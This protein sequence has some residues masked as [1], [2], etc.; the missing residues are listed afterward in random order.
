MRILDMFRN[1]DS[2]RLI[3]REIC[4]IAEAGVNHEGDLDLAYRLVEEAAEGGAD[5]IKFQAYKAGALASVHSP[6]YWDNTKETTRSQYELFQK[7][8]GFGP[9][10]YEKIKLR[11]DSNKIDFLCTAFDIESIEFINDLVDVHK[12]A[13]A[14]IT[15]QP[16]IEY[17]SACGKPVL[18]S[19]GAATLMEIQIALG[20]LGYF[21][22]LLHCVLNYPTPDKNAN[23][24]R[25]QSLHREFPL[26]P[27]GY[28]DHTVP[29]GMMN[30]L[31]AVLLGAVIIEKH[32]TFDKTLPGNDHYHSM[33][34]TDLVAFREK[35]GMMC[36][37][38][39]T[40]E[41]DPGE[42]EALAR[43][44]ARRSLVTTKTL[45]MGHIIIGSDLTWKRPA[46]G[47]M[48]YHLS[49]AIGRK[50]T[51]EL[52]EDTIVKRDDLNGH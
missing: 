24:G 44:H 8:D 16:L 50:T 30:I 38:L 25:I 37:T 21:P 3:S 20:W 43:S 51:I 17:I 33:D 41:I 22:A 34:K 35:W 7:Y 40:G 5:A 11:C 29:D 26:C 10:D 48:P 19:T 4:V 14:D 36:D 46:H 12:I 1:Y 42:N 27:I 15:C 13:S 52:D 9:S 23:L 39:G 47:L 49:W 45:P 18:M 32:F 2:D 31:A 28:S 6:A